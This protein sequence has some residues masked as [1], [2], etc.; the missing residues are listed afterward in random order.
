VGVCSMCIIG[1]LQASSFRINSAFD[2]AFDS[3]SAR[4]DR[5]LGR[6]AGMSE[7]VD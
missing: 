7:G 3:R 5:S 2:S 6:L 1:C 4:G